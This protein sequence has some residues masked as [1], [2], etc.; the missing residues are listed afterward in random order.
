MVIVGGGLAAGLIARQLVR[1]HV[2]TVVLERGGDHRQGAEGRIPTQRDEL[3]WDVRSG[4]I[5]DAANETYTLRRSGTEQS[6]P[7]RRLSAFLPGT[8]VGGAGSH[9]GGQ[10]WRWA[11]YNLALRS[12]LE[13]RYGRA[14][15]PADMP[16]QDWGV[17]YDEL[18]PYH[19]LFEKL[20]GISGK[21]GN[22]RGKI[23][24]GGNPFESPRANE[25]PQPPLEI[26]EAGVIFKA[27]VEREFGYRPFPSPAANSPG[28]YVNP[29]GMR[30]GACQ[31]CGH[32][33]RFICEANAKGA[34]DV[35]LYPWLEQQPGFELRPRCHVTG[36]DH[37]R[38][39][40][41]VLGV[42]YLDLV[43]GEETFQPAGA[44]VL[45][46]FTMTNTRLLLAGGLGRPYSPE[47]GEGVVGK[48]FCY[49]ANSGLNLFFRERWMNPFLAAG[50]TGTIIDEY[51]DDN[52]DHTG[53]GFL[54]GGYIGVNVSSGRPINQRRV[55]PGTPRWGTAWKQANADWYAHSCSI[56]A[57]G[58]CYPHRENYLDLDPDY[59]DAFGQPL[60][61]MNFDFRENERR[62]SAFCTDQALKIARAMGATLLGPAVPRAAPFDTRVYQGSHVT[63][64]TIMGVEPATS[65]V[66]PRLQHWDAENLFVAG[67]SV[68]AHNAGHNPTGPVAALALR[69]GDDLVRYVAKPARL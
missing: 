12:R 37:D 14:A 2:D 7:M 16:L 23:Q 35:L 24:P 69:L 44:V 31:Y 50:G 22:L 52:F 6:R 36:L 40:G 48:N 45:A 54:G 60:L 15:I 19:D 26:T 34:P 68:F 9:W 33:E 63:G 20:F 27:A 17:T 51:N 4:L 66:S 65:V 41:R 18:E 8:G 5:Q 47:T 56:G 61:R 38:R 39:T 10:T 53:L 64:G 25:Y 11:G 59:T 62:V 49:Q 13:Q 43:T 58:S 1:Q 21:A 28:A 29:D 30:L 55:P 32:C 42:R 46:A 57:Q 67:A 3:R